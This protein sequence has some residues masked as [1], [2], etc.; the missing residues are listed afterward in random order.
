MIYYSMK[1]M[2]YV[3]TNRL[4]LSPPSH[5]ALPGCDSTGRGPA[6]RRPAPSRAA[7]YR[8]ARQCSPH[9]GSGSAPAASCGTARPPPRPPGGSDTSQKDSKGYFSAHS[10]G[11]W[12]EERPPAS[13]RALRK[14]FKG[15]TGLHPG[16]LQ[17]Q[18][19]P[20]LES[21]LSKAQD[22]E[23]KLTFSQRSLI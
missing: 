14:R 18:M 8:R 17:V 15:S 6:M 10:V 12:P 3:R 13:S 4:R 1:S 21:P 19:L 11:L 23:I 20:R 7:R 22:L 16:P 2:T 5:R 9:T